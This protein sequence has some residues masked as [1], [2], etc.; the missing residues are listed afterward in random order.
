MAVFG[1]QVNHLK[2]FLSSCPQNLFFFLISVLGFWGG[3]CRVAPPPLWCAPIWHVCSL[4]HYI[5]HCL[6]C[7]GLEKLASWF[8]TYFTICQLTPCLRQVGTRA[9]VRAKASPSYSL[10]IASNLCRSDC[11]PRVL[12]AIPAAIFNLAC[13]GKMWK[14]ITWKVCQLSPLSPIARR[15]DNFSV[16]GFRPRV[17]LKTP[18]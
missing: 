6:L 5:N 3:C 17:H 11:S 14:I 4:K 18:N 12:L 16:E 10:R 13:T 9:E 2:I 7:L 1:L 15:F 8:S